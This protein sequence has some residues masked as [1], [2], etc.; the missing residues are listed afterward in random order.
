M[1][2]SP[3]RLD[4]RHAGRPRNGDVKPCPKC[5]HPDC[6]FSERYRFE[7]K[8]NIPGWLCD[9][10]GCGFRELVRNNVT[11]TT[12]RRP[13]ASSIRGSRE[14]RARARREMMKARA[15]IVRSRKQLEASGRR[16]KKKR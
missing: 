11:A 1:A 14:L 8:G 5:G 16:L 3:R 12:A 7:G 6:E 2:L 9:A 4:R 15:K 10:P 13:S